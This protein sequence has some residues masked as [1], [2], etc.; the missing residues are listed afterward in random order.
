PDDRIRR[1]HGVRARQRARDP[2][3]GG[4]RHRC[5]RTGRP[6]PPRPDRGAMRRGVLRTRLV[7]LLGAGG[8]ALVLL[9]PGLL[10]W[11]LT[12][13]EGPPMKRPARG[14]A[15]DQIPDDA[16]LVLVTIEGLRADR[17]GSYGESPLSPTPHIDRPAREGYRFEQALTPVPSAF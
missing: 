17:L 15:R 1:L 11:R 12:P 2:A 4:R 10:A 7:D 13:P 8:F 14:P 5:G 9:L 16:S 6:A 3:R